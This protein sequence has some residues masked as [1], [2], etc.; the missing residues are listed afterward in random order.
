M[1]PTCSSPIAARGAAP[2]V[3]L[4]A[5]APP[6]PAQAHDARRLGM[7]GIML[8]EVSRL[9]DAERRLPRRAEAGPERRGLQ[10][11]P[12]PLGL[13][14]VL[15]DP[16]ES[17]PTNPNFNVFEIAN[18][19]A[20]RRTRSSSSSP[21]SCRATSSSTSPEPA[22]RRPGRAAAPVPRRRRSATASRSAV[23]EPRVRHAN[24]FVGVRPQA[25]GRITLDLDR[26]APG[27]ARRGRAVPAQHDLRHR[28][29]RRRPRPRSRSRAARRC[30]SCRPRRARR[31]PAPGRLRPLR[32]RAAQVPARHR[33]LAAP[34]RGASPPATRSSARRTPI[35][36]RL[37]VRTS[38]RRPN[39]GSTPE[40]VG[41]RRGRR[42]VRQ[43]VRDRPRRQ[44]PRHDDHL[45]AHGPRPLR[46]TTRPRTT[47]VRT[48][49]S[50]AT[51]STRASSR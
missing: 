25:D 31:R 11:I 28:A 44:R 9:G 45:G 39:P 51:S 7:G 50:R 30:R 17:I 2:R 36:G 1:V 21:R 35:D 42:V 40:G 8:S 18:L 6:R 4:A 34:T 15:A 12:L 43:P 19:I 38:A 5:R 3:P 32:R 10:P 41:G 48:D 26:R 20:A 24:V 33:A 23:A 13:I 47:N 37:R 16:P 27:G 46:P 49:G 14:Q 29:T 22:R